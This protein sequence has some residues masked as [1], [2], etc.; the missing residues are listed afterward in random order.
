MGTE[1]GFY[2]SIDGGA[3][4]I[5]LKSGLPA[6]PVRDIAIQK[7]ECDIVIATFGRGFYIIDDYSPL[8]TATKE[9][10]DKP[11]HIFTIKDA[12]MYVPSGGGTES[13]TNFFRSA[14]PDFGATFTYYLKDVPKT[15]KT[16]RKEKEK[17]LSKE[18][19]PIP[20]PSDEELRAESN[21]TAPYLIFTITDESGN[22]VRTINR[23]A[24]KGI[25]R[26]NWDLR[27]QAFSPVSVTGKFSPV[28][29]GAGGRGFGGGNLAMPGKY[30]VSL[31]IVSRE[32]TKELT[33]PLEFNAVVLRNTTL[34]ASDRA[35]LVAF[36]KKATQLA[37][38]IQATQRFL[39][40]MITR[41]ENI[42]AAI[43]SSTSGSFELMNKTQ[44]I[45]LALEDIQLKFNRPSSRPS[46]EENPP[47][48][49]TI[50]DRLGD[51]ASTHFRSTSN[52]TTLETRSYDILMEEFPPVLE[53]LKKIYNEDIK[54]IES[55]LEKIN[56]P[57]STGRIPELKK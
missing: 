24:S 18:N 51:M 48:P 40:E 43:N 12:L 46:A 36:Q 45:S 16:I 56:A 42:K 32:G 14:N 28:Q 26:I 23:S 9:V 17:G 4:W 11:A 25:Q 29:S 47:S 44:K 1:F 35:A 50:N 15:L 41:V 19:K 22:V 55:E 8:R 54:A 33:A 5:A 30:K 27:Y 53:Q 20:V 3:K 31:A 10:Y 34:P 39:N 57:W 38:T 49:P 13:G 37:Q 7:R 21:E 52:L 2:F 6:I